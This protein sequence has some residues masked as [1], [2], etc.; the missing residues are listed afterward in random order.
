MY[1]SINKLHIKKGNQ[2]ITA[3]DEQE[4]IDRL[5]ILEN[6]LVDSTQIIHN[7]TEI[8]NDG[9]YMCVPNTITVTFDT[10]D[11]VMRYRDGTKFIANVYENGVLV[12][13]TKAQKVNN[14]SSNACTLIFGLNGVY[15]A[16]PYNSN[17][18]G[19]A[20]NLNM[21]ANA[22]PYIITTYYVDSLGQ[23]HST[24]NTITITS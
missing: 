17:N 18:N 10:H 8:D 3:L 14:F 21:M 15:Y 12:T 23:I 24:T 19:V 5:D 2:E 16:R 22:N 7:E 4:I 9:I 20:L 13:D 1:E 6:V 11:I